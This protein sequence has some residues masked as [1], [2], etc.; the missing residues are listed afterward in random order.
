MDGLE[1]NPA[2]RRTRPTAKIIAMTAGEGVRNYLDA[3]K[4]LGAHDT[5]KKPFTRQELLDVVASQLK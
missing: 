2:L 1:L 3:A 5:L 4:H